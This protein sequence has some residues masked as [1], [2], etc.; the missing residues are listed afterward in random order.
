MV[1]FED[2]RKHQAGILRRNATQC[3][4]QIASNCSD[5]LFAAANKCRANLFIFV[6]YKSGHGLD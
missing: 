2:R 1:V 5:L 4:V 6:E 3:A